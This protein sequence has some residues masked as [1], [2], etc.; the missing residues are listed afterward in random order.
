MGKEK[1][2]ATVYGKRAYA[3]IEH[4]RNEIL[5]IY[6]SAKCEGHTQD[7]VLVRVQWRIYDTA[8]Y[9]RL[10]AYGKTAV[11]SALRIMQEY[12]WRENVTFARLID[13]EIAIS[14]LETPEQWAR[15]VAGERFQG[16]FVWRHDPT[17]WFTL[18]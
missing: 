4:M 11:Y 9:N 7:F 5:S 10:P 2:T 17:K 1:S 18:G 14:R 8:D 16:G 15:I 12:T 6:T 13:G 3:I